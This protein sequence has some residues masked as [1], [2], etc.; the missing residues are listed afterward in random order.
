MIFDESTPVSVCVHELM[1]AKSILPVRIL[2]T[3][4]VLLGTRDDQARMEWD[5]W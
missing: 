3:L 2:Q 4:N 5:G 1:L